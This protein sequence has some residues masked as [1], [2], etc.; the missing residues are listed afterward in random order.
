MFGSN[1]FHS[2]LYFLIVAEAW[3]LQ[4]EALGRGRLFL[5]NLRLCRARSAASPVFQV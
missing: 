1:F 5:F 2:L 3:R 4:L